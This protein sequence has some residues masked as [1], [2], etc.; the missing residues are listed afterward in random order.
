[1]SRDER[2]GQILTHDIK[3]QTSKTLLLNT[4]DVTV[5]WGCGVGRGLDSERVCMYVCM[6]CLHF[7]PILIAIYKPHLI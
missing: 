4:K 2:R 5:G 1:M 6:R 7:L 3:G